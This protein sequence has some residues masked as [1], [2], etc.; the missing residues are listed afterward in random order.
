[1]GFEGGDVNLTRYVGGNPVNYIDPLGLINVTKTAVG[2]INVGRGILA[3]AKGVSAALIGVVGYGSGVGWPLGAGATLLSA[4][5]LGIAFPGLVSRGLQQVEQGLRECE[6]KVSFG[7]WQNLRGLGPWGQYV[8]DPNET[9]SSAFEYKK[10]QL[11]QILRSIHDAPH[12]A[13]YPLW[14]FLKDFAM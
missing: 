3:G 9:Y 8:D 5:Q 7:S 12:K 2:V 1:M 14:V 11:D 10:M 6:G 4:Y 13:L